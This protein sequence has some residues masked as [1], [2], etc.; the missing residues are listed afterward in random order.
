MN[1]FGMHTP[2]KFSAAADCGSQKI[3][4][5]DH[6]NARRDALYTPNKNVSTS[7]TPPYYTEYEI[8]LYS[9][10]TVLPPPIR[11]EVYTD[12]LKGMSTFFKATAINNGSAMDQMPMPQSEQ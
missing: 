7:L 8:Y 3:P 5:C 12:S 11:D 1:D 10:K 9:P 2:P 4:L 6:S